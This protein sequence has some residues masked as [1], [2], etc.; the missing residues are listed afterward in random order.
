MKKD[1]FSFF[2]TPGNWDKNIWLAPQITSSKSFEKVIL[3]G[4]TQNYWPPR[5]R[6]YFFLPQKTLTRDHVCLLPAAIIDIAKRGKKE[7]V[8]VGDDNSQRV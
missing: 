8:K 1:F 4:I 7:D 6:L 5:K 3:P 2:A